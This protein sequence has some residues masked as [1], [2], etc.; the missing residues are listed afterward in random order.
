MTNKDKNI[1]PMT[2][3]PQLQQMAE[4]VQ[5]AYKLKKEEEKAPS[6]DEVWKRFNAKHHVTEEVPAEV[7]PSITPRHSFWKRYGVAASLLLACMVAVAITVVR[8]V[9]FPPSEETDAS[10]SAELNAAMD[11]IPEE[12]EENKTTI[13]YRNIALSQIV[14]QLAQEH[15]ARVEYLASGDVR[16]YV[17]L[18][19]SWSLQ[20][21]LDFLNHFEQ[22]NL[23]LTSDQVIE[24]R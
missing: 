11:D 5:Q 19:R 2:D 15:N 18:D 1:A 22:V 23:S 13:V 8:N 21:S 20:Q 16:L 7:S 14:E 24:V 17:E 4:E 10:P 3:D 12:I 9:A 6:V